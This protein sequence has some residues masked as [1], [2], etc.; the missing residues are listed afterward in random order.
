MAQYFTY[1]EQEITHLKARDKRLAEIIELIGRCAVRSCPDLFEALIHAIVGQQIATRAQ[2]TIWARMRAGL[3]A[4]TPGVI[5]ETSE[6]G[7]QAFGLSFR[8]V[9][10]MKAAA[11]R[12]LSR[13][14]RCGG[15]AD[16]ARRR[17]LRRTG[18]PARRGRL[19]GRNADDFLAAAARRH[20][21]RRSGYSAR[22]AH[23]LPPP[24]CSTANSS[25]NTGGVT[26][27]MPQ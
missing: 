20:K 13:R 17:A 8:K 26:R 21:L 24:S 18:A 27:P 15:P 11:E 25:T 10:Y 4:I 1:G 7:L 16:P 12:V 14:I 19:D 23:A 9:G 5:R 3:G 22:P 6:T 2:Q